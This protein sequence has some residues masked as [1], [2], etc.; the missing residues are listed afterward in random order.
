MRRTVALI[1]GTP[2]CGSSLLN[3]LLDSQPAVRG[4]GEALNLLPGQP[5][6]PCSRCGEHVG[7]CPLYKAT[8]RSRFYGSLFDFYPN[9]SVLIDSSKDFSWCFLLHR[10]EPAFAYKPIVLSKAP[11]EFARSWLGHHPG[12]SAPAA[13]LRYIEFYTQQLDWLA[14]QPWFTPGDCKAIAYRELARRPQRALKGVCDFL[15]VP[16]SWDPAWWRSDSHIIGGNGIVSAQ[17][18]PAPTGAARDPDYLNGKYRGRFHT[19]FYDAQWRTDA[20]QLRA[21]RTLY[22]QFAPRLESLL[23]A[24]GQP[25]CRQLDL[26]LQSCAP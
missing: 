17:T 12:D 10:F 24:L 5:P 18:S 20:A 13:Y 4:L 11:H 3:L 23:Q 19:I 26:E 16:Y 8:D 21:F 7:A 1:I 15:G 9:S 2:Y 22:R 25:D 14:C 6:A